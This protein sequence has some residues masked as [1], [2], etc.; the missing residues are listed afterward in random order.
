MSRTDSDSNQDDKVAQLSEENFKIYTLSNL[1]KSL[2]I[3][4]WQAGRRLF[5]RKCVGRG[6]ISEKIID[7][8]AELCK[9][10]NKIACFEK[11]TRLET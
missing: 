5:T 3:P 7:I 4:D 11:E 8:D 1:S 9:P 2:S 10:W 6:D